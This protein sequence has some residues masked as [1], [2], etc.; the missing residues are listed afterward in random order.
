VFDFYLGDPD[1][2]Q[3]DERSFLV[4]V[5]QLLPKAIN[6]LPDSEYL[7]LYDS[8]IDSFIP[9]LSKPV[10]IETGIGASTIVLAFCAA[11][12]DGQLFSWDTNHLK[13]GFIKLCLAD[14]V[15]R[16][17]GKEVSTFW[18]FVPHSSTQTGIGIRV[19]D[20]LN[21]APVHAFLDGEHTWDTLGEEIRQVTAVGET[22]MLI[23][24]DDGNY[25]FSQVNDAQLNLGRR[26]LG[27]P[28]LPTVKSNTGAPFYKRAE[29]LLTR[30]WC[31][32][33]RVPDTF[34]DNCADDAYYRYY[35]HHHKLA[36]ALNLQS[37]E[38][39]GHRFSCW[40]VASKRER[41]AR[42]RHG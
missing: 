29:S 14:H 18:T 28:L 11:K 3:G 36:S 23:A 16:H 27:L 33:D 40:R 35:A 26:R 15:A 22:E 9:R 31:R 24:L 4:S 13:G 25:T 2:I 17:F 38:I 1:Q 34:K 7:A 41:H 20:E 8:I 6:L 12:Y 39:D 10:F 19:L 5:K 37:A 32:V 30:L 21:R 42:S